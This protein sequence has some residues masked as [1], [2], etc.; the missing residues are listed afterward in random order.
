MGRKSTAKAVGD[1]SREALAKAG[2][3]GKL[4]GTDGGLTLNLYDAFPDEHDNEE[5]LWV[6]IDSLAVPL[7]T[8][9]FERRGRSGAFVRFA[10]IDTTQRAQEL[11]GLDIFVRSS[12]EKADGELY[13]EDLEGFTAVIRTEGRPDTTG[14]VEAY[15]DNEFNP[16]FVVKASGGGEI[17]IPASDD[18]LES[19]NAKRR[20]VAFTLPEGL[21]ELN[22]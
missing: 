19:V 14:V 4:F 6:I 20:E 7:F 16:L 3:I 22:V 8:E 1:T 21:V 18:F 11:V 2:R 15:V 13:F 5:P 17:L 10:D 9:H 12:E